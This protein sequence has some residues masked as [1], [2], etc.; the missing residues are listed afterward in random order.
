MS[1]WFDPLALE[2]PPVSVT[3]ATPRTASVIIDRL[4]F[5]ARNK[6]DLVLECQGPGE[7]AI[8]CR[9]RIDLFQS[10]PGKNA[11]VSTGFMN[12]QSAM[13]GSYCN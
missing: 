3:I 6:R 4:D 1:G 7:P 12:F 2:K 9:E 10:L 11:S 5:M 13:V 8:R